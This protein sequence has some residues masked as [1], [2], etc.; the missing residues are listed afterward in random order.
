MFQKSGKYVISLLLI[1]AAL[2]F[3]FFAGTRMKEPKAVSNQK[4][5]RRKVNLYINILNFKSGIDK[6]D[7]TMR[8]GGGGG[9]ISYSSNTAGQ[10]LAS[11]KFP[12]PPFPTP[13]EYND[14]ESEIKAEL[15]KSGRD[16]VPFSKDMTNTNTT[17]SF[18]VSTKLS[19]VKDTCV[20]YLSVH[21]PE[22]TYEYFGAR[23]K[24]DS[25]RWMH[26]AIMA[27]LHKVLYQF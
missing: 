17:P 1:F 25:K 20:L 7:L 13:T 26:D 24:S 18:I 10:F 27:T 9:K 4:P 5:G 23:K 11:S 8:G 6:S 2:M 21:S 12:K 22:G 3:G 15:A 16:V 19:I 14:L